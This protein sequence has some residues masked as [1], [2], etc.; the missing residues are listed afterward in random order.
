MTKA[1]ASNGNLN[2]YADYTFCFKISNLNVPKTGAILLDWPQELFG[3]I[4]GTAYDCTM[5]KGGV[6]ESVTCTMD[7][8][9][10][11]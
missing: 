11:N 1:S 9:T 4:K 6:V 3:L 8:I 10:G 5:T 2:S 7:A